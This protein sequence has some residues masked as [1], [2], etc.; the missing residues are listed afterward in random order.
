MPAAAPE[1]AW[2]RARVCATQLRVGHQGILD[3]RNYLLNAVDDVHPAVG[4]LEAA[5]PWMRLV[6]SPSHR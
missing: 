5:A 2:V 6:R 1:R 4:A 3:Q